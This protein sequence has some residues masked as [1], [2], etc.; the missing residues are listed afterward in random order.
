[1]TPPRKLL[2]C[3]AS[4]VWAT[5]MG[6]GAGAG[7]G[8]WA[9]A[10][11]L[12]ASAVS[13]QDAPPE[14]SSFH[15]APAKP[16]RQPVPPLEWQRLARPADAFGPRRWRATDT[17]MLRAAQQQRWDLVA[18][19]AR[20][21]KA[22]ARASDERG[23]LALVL[24][25][26]AGQ[27]EAVLQLLRRGAPVDARDGQG[28]TAL[29]V[30]AQAGH[31][32]L[33]RMLLR[34]GADPTRWSANGQAPLHLAALAGHVAV[35]QALLTL[36]TPLELLNNKRETALDV[37]AQSGQLEVMDHLLAAGADAL[38]AGRR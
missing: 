1:V 15:T 30:A 2:A 37:A 11:A 31:L 12:G 23:T 38:R 16:A 34:E 6:A 27:E 22:D 20:E 9:L 3:M 13:A 8:A 17:E 5:N 28:H 29:G 33:V 4:A 19:L 26:R 7:A 25:A 32:Q 21:G 14:F 35:M 10:L 24:A 36:G 18:T